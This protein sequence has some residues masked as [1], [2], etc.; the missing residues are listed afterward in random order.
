MAKPNFLTFP[1]EIREKILGHVF[2]GNT[3][4][5]EAV[6]ML[7]SWERYLPTSRPIQMK[8]FSRTETPTILLTCKQVF[9]EG[10]VIF[11]QHSN[12]HVGS[13]AHQLIDM[14]PEK[15]KHIRLEPIKMPPYFKHVDTIIINGVAALAI[16]VLRLL[17]NVQTLD[18]GVR[19]IGLAIDKKPED[20]T[21]DQIVKRMALFRVH[22]SDLTDIETVTKV[23][24]TV[25]TDGREH[26]AFVLYSQNV[27]QVGQLPSRWLNVAYL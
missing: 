1:V 15:V 12:I 4:M 16:P 8:F 23:V 17:P 26:S 10:L 14:D 7:P 27:G 21:F 19:M 13:S 6:F 2:H 5:S 22:M 9:R 11:W 20:V 3:I 18:L 24:G 25:E